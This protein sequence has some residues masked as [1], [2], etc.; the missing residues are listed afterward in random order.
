MSCR[1]DIWELASGTGQVGGHMTRALLLA[2]EV[3]LLLVQIPRN[4]NK[5][6]LTCS[7]FFK[8]LASE[9]TVTQ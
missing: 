8:V 7:R 1:G 6:I 3:H 4:P 2:A 5:S 9:L